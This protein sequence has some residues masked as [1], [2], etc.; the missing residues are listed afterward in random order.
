MCLEA[1]RATATSTPTL[2]FTPTGA[3]LFISDTYV[4]Q[5]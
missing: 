1:L 4:H 2:L 3:D 5:P